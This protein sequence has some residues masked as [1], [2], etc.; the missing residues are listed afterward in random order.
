LHKSNERKGNGQDR[1]KEGF[2]TLIMRRNGATTLLEK[3][4]LHL[5]SHARAVQETYPFVTSNV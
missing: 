3:L 1:A 2:L 5:L 4:V